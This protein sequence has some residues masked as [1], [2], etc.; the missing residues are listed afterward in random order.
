MENAAVTEAT[1][2]S[3]SWELNIPGHS[4]ANYWTGSL[5]GSTP[6]PTYGKMTLAGTLNLSGAVHPQLTFWHRYN[7]NYYT[8][9]Y[10]QVATGKGPS[11]SYT[12]VRE[13]RNTT[14]NNWVQEQIDLTPYAGMS[15]VRLRFYLRQEDGSW[16]WG[17]SVD[18]IRLDET[19]SVPPSAITDLSASNPTANSINLTWTSPGDDANTGKA[20]QYDVRYSTSTITETNWGTA[21]KVLGLPAPRLP[22][23]MESF[24]VSGLN[25]FTTYYFAMKTADEVPN[26]STLSNVAS[27]KT[28]QTGVA[29]VTVDAPKEVLKDKDF[30]ARIRLNDVKSFDAANYTIS[31]DSAVLQFVSATAGD[32]GGTQV[33]VSGINQSSGSVNVLQNIPD[34]PGVSGSGYLAVLNFHVIGAKDS[35][36]AITPSG[37]VLSDKDAKEIA[38]NWAGDSVLVVLVLSGDAN[39]D[40]KVDALDITKAERI[41][42][43][44]DNVTP[45]ADANHDGNVNALDITKIERIILELD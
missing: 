5:K 42:I 40:D 32:I 8:W 12:T 18:D 39:A 21:T 44:L 4:G 16:P 15:V 14:Q 23:T 19:D 41:V 43:G 27:A 24:T 10:V 7:L 20:W 17:W 1:W 26:W 25:P 31:F 2:L 34:A 29:L 45:G 33:P 35:T 3:S 11:Q 38:S 13:L 6:H 28:F 36:S 22:N 37:G 9:L 30:S